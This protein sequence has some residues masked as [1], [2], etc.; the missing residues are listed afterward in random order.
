[1][2][3]VG[4]L[5]FALLSISILS[6]GVSGTAFAAHHSDPNPALPISS[7]TEIYTNGAGVTIS[8]TIKNYDSSSL[9][10][11]AV[12]YTVVSP[13]D[14]FVAIGQLMPNSDGS[15]KFNFIAG[16]VLWKTNGDYPISVKYGPDDSEITVKYVGGEQVISEPEPTPEPTPEP[17]PT[18]GAGTALVNGICQVVKTEEP[19]GGGCLIATAAYGSELAPQVQFLREIRDNTVM[20]TSSGAA[21]MS[22]FNQLYYSFSPT[23]ADMEREN[24][25]FKEAVRAFITPMVSTL[26]IMTLADGGSEVEVLGL[27]ISVIALNLGMY[28]AAPALIGFKV[29]K[30]IKSRK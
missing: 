19:K 8:G 12:T 22:G 24:P 29:N 25:M 2:R 18:C 4:F 26:S 13:T 21:F 11:G 30:I 28:I 27:G 9:T 15:F 17:E 3:L 20:S 23:I 5:A 14:S 7:N 10:A 6:Y 16:G 1:M